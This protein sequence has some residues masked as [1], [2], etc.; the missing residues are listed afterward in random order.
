MKHIIL[1]ALAL[2]LP[3]ASLAGSESSLR[4]AG[5]IV[6]VGDA[7]IDLLGKCGAPTLREVRAFDSGAI[8]TVAPGFGRAAL[9]VS[10]RWTYD[11]GPQSFTMS[12]TVEGGKAGD[13]LCR[14][15]GRRHVAKRRT[16]RGS[17]GYR[18]YRAR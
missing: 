5:G 17:A 16:G 15:F 6:S 1:A 11:F 9:N 10:E 7:T 4:C 3:A 12:V 13:G 18:G 14:I 8:V 2:T